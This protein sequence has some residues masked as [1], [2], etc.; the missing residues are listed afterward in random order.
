MAFAKPSA[1]NGVYPAYLFKDHDPVLDQVDTVIADSGMKLSGVAAVAH[2]SPTTLTN[3]RMR[4]TK[5]PQFASVAAVVRAVGGEITIT[6]GGRTI[7]RP[8]NT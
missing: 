3:W 8:P 2:I 6:F 5:R 4:K 1:Y 7:D